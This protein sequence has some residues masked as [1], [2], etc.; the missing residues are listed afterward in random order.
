MLSINHIQYLLLD[1]FG[2]DETVLKVCSIDNEMIHIQFQNFEYTER[3]FD[4]ENPE[5]SDTDFDALE[6]IFFEIIKCKSNNSE[7]FQ[8]Y[9][10][11]SPNGIRF[12]KLVHFFVNE[13]YFGKPVRVDN[14]NRVTSDSVYR[15]IQKYLSY[16]MVDVLIDMFQLNYLATE[17]RV[18]TIYF[19]SDFDYINLWSYLGF[20]KTI[21]RFFKHII[22]LRRMLFIEEFWSVILSKRYLL[23]N[24][25]LTKSMF[26][27]KDKISD[28]LQV[29]NIGFLLVEKSHKKYD[30]KNDYSQL[31]F[32]EYLNRVMG[33]VSFGI[34]PSYN[35][36]Y[37]PESLKKQIETI[38]QVI[39]EYPKYSRF[40]YL[41]CCYPDDLLPLEKNRIKQDFSFY[42][43]DNLLF[44]G[45][46]SRPFKQWSYKENRAINVEIIPLTIM[47][48]TLRNTLKLTFEEAEKISFDK[49]KNTLLLGQSCVL[50]WHN[51][52]MYEPLSRKS[53]SRKLML[54]IKN[55]VEEIGNIR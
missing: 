17:K 46:I 9:K 41:N 16:P 20:F 32:K 4:F 29:K 51:N 54:S 49:I 12:L 1:V 25:M 33:N 7:L 6:T 23:R 31:S 53:Y 48:V 15:N 30:F 18:R 40:H 45:A 3:C 10:N 37:K 52:E 28:S 38:E 11:V 44:R 27:F 13:H 26:L 2:I 22:F 24:V 55:Y 34:H 19:T 50:L 5:L 39:F 35:T 42:F 43:C 47:D 8:L 21:W 36:R 14:H